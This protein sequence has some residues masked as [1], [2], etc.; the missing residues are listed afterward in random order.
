MEMN[1]KI[2]MENNKQTTIT[3]EEISHMELITFPGRIVVVQSLREAE[4]AVEYLRSLQVIGFDTETKPAFRKGQKNKVALLQLSG[5]DY[6]FLFRLNIIGFPEC[7]IQL[8][9]DPAILKIGLSIK[10][11]YATMRRLANFEPDGFVELQHFV[12][13]FDIEE[14]SL[15]KIFALLFGR[16]I[17]K[18]QRVTNW[19]ADV[20]TEGQKKYAATDAWA[21]LRIYEALNE[22][23]DF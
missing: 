22:A 1:G 12:K 15:Q 20:L 13:Q 6:C 7:L 23:L 19:E 18:S 16:K 10:D 3:K 4:K 21:C 14:A 8:L 2:G 5:N 9:K 11:D 17:S